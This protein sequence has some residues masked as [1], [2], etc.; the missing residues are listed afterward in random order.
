MAVLRSSCSDQT[1]AC[2]VAKLQSADAI[3]AQPLW[4]D[5][6]NLL[7]TIEAALAGGAVI[8]GRD[9]CYRDMASMHGSYRKVAETETALRSIAKFLA[10]HCSTAPVCWWLD[11]PVS[12]SG[13]LR[14]MIDAMA[15]EE[16]WNWTVELVDNPDRVLANADA[17]VATADGIV[18]DECQRWVNLSRAIVDQLI[19]TA[20]IVRMTRLDTWH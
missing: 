17:I 4:I 10:H 6:F 9:G 11:R 18:L 15:A 13:R 19:P 8:R 2:R 12:N 7:T 5:G 3:G 16:K 14:A 20:W 1:L